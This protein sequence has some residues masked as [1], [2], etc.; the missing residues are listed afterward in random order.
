MNY[1]PPKHVLEYLKQKQ[2]ESGLSFQT[3]ITMLVTEH[4]STT[5]PQSTK[6]GRE[7]NGTETEDVFTN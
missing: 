6:S 5:T 4:L 3:I 7:T 1:T 2:Q